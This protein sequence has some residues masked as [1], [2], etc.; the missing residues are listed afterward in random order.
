MSTVPKRESGAGWGSL[1]QTLGGLRLGRQPAV[2]LQ[3]LYPAL[4]L[5]LPGGPW[6]Q[7]GGGF[8]SL[9]LHVRPSGPPL[10]PH[11]G[12]PLFTPILQRRKLTLRV[13]KYLPRVPQPVR[14]PAG[15]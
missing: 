1:D 7:V 15:F 9:L 8:P 10:Q 14:G 13:V 5:A 6:G 12:G 3:I 11:R 4:L 2:P